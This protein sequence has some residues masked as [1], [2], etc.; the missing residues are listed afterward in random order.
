MTVNKFVA[1]SSIY[2]LTLPAGVA[3][4]KDDAFQSVQKAV[5]ERTGKGVRWEQD[6]AAREQALQNVRQLLRKPLTV[7]TAVQI[8]FLNNRALQ[9][10]FEEIGLLAADVLEA[11]T[12]PNP[13]FDLAIRF[14]DKP[15]SGTYIDYS[16]A[17]D[18]LSII[19]IPLKAR[20]ERSA[21]ICSF[22]CS[23]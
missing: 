18:F 3:G 23:R 22:A 9:A 17:I 1:F 11:A 13:R 14:P 15:P 20:C 10:T 4:E 19:I 8:A 2:A 6:Q 7:D 21:G 16:A 12:I 5:Q